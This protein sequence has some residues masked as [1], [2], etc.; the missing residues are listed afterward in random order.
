MWSVE[1]DPEAKRVLDL[2]LAK[3]IKYNA[4]VFCVEIDPDGHRVAVGLSEGPTYLTELKTGSN[5]WLV[6]DSLPQSLDIWTDLIDFSALVDRYEKADYRVGVFCLQ[7]SPDGQILAT[8]TYDGKIKV[9]YICS[10]KTIF[11]SNL[12]P[13]SLDLGHRSKTDEGHV[14]KTFR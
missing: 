6:S 1:Y 5:I 2:H 9:Y 7:F 10:L 14:Q 3:V 4:S 12:T 13:C 11:P 8:G